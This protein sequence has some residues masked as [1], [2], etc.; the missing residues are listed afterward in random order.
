MGAFSQ[1]WGRGAASIMWLS[2]GAM[3]H[4]T[5]FLRSLRL[6]RIS[7]YITKGI[8]VNYR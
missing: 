8:F 1:N 4:S 6:L 3:E 7:L 2:M 5:W